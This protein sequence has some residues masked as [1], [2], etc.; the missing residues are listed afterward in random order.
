M[1][2]QQP[3]SPTSGVHPLR[4]IL[5][6]AALFGLGELA[7]LRFVGAL[8]FDRT[9]ATGAVAGGWASTVG[10]F[11]LDFAT[12]LV[13]VSL[14]VFAL[15]PLRWRSG[16]S[17]TLVGYV[18]IAAIL[19]WAS[20]MGPWVPATFG[21]ISAAITLVVGLVALV[22][23]NAEG[24]FAI[25]LLLLAF[26]CAYVY[27]LSPAFLSP[28]SIIAPGGPG[29]LGFGEVLY[30][31]AGAFAFYAWGWRRVQ[32][33]R[34]GLYIGLAAA[35]ALALYFG[36]GGPSA[37]AALTQATGLTVFLPVWVYVVSTFFFATTAFSCILDR[38]SFA[39]GAAFLL[40]LIAGLLPVTSYQQALVVMG[41]VLLAHR[42]DAFR[43]GAE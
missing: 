40:F 18:L 14:V 22:R 11:F 25:G 1:A 19:P 37:V 12:I 6:L 24:K 31:V 20:A 9:I 17:F 41:M 15:T 28:S 7:L 13:F 16:W 34:T 10:S 35:L 38:D 42:Q 39:T 33:N 2:V 26:V 21:F 27:A 3:L 32:E 43:M 4:P 30:V 36:V 8:S 5:A 29:T 23:P